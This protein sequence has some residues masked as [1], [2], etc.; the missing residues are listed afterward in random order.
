MRICNFMDTKYKNKSRSRTFITVALVTREQVQTSFS[1]CN[2]T[3]RSSFL[4][5]NKRQMITK[6]LLRIA[7]KLPY[8]HWNT[9]LI[10]VAVLK[11]TLDIGFCNLNSVEN[12]IFSIAFFCNVLG[13]PE[14]YCLAFL[15]IS[16]HTLKLS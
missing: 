3:P 6:T 2:F 15:N 7:L 4:R 9:L 16:V 12:F 11:A 10:S 13:I 5:E 14:N 1:N 8:C